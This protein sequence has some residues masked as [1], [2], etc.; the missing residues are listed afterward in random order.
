MTK[1]PKNIGLKSE[2]LS[3]R[4]ADTKVVKIKI[5]KDLDDYG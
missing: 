2:A 5:F 3:F 1:N 4:I